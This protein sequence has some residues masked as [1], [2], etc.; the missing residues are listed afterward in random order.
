MNKRGQGLSV[1]AIIMIVL[2]LFVLAALI[3]GFTLG[4][5]DLKDKFTSSNN[6]GNIVSACSTACLTQSEFDFCTFPRE[7][8]MNEDTLGLINQKENKKSEDVANFVLTNKYTCNNLLNYT[9]LGIQ[10]CSSICN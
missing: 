4:F 8:K 10:D 7:L 1:N 3:L 5:G 6:V 2:G 9:S